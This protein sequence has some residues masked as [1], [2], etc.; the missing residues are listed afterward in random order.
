MKTLTPTILVL[1][2]I[3]TAAELLDSGKEV[4]ELSV[5]MSDG[6]WALTSALVGLAFFGVWALAK[7]ASFVTS[8]TK[9][10]PIKFVPI[11]YYV[12]KNTARSWAWRDAE[13][14]FPCER[15]R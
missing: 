5:S 13:G 7:A 12:E 1:K 15:R 10:A 3:E 14:T 8:G 4:A 9:S 11:F 6:P 2:V